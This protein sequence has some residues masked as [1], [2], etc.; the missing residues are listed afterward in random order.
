M[1]IAAT[2]IL[3]ASALLVASTALAGWAPAV[4]EIDLGSASMGVTLLVGGLLVING[5]RRK[6]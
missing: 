5:L 2:L 1:R 3:I 6:H 4:P